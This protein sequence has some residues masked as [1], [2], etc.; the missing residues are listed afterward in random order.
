MLTW[1]VR[2]FKEEGMV[3]L[4]HVHGPHIPL[5]LLPLFVSGSYLYCLHL[6]N[7]IRPTAF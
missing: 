2:E 3:Y 7:L 4:S 5:V 6:E 1:F